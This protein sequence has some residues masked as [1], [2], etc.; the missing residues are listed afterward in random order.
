MIEPE[1]LEKA[2][3]EIDNHVG[4][5]RLVDEAD[6]PKLKYLQSIISETL[7]LFPAA[8]MLL[9]HESSEDCKVAGFHIPRGTMLLVNAWAIHRDPLHWEDP[10]SFKLER[11]EGVEVESWKLLPFGMGRR[12]CPGSGLA[13]RVVGLALGT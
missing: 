10:D 4:K 13:Q 1:V 9:P 3:T 2:R 6:L 11:F 7:R 5:D 12:A 8:P